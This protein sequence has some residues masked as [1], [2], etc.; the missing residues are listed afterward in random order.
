MSR[1]IGG[2]VMVP[3][4]HLFAA[5]VRQDVPVHPSKP[6]EFDEETET[7][8]CH[9]CNGGKLLRSKGDLMQHLSTDGHQMA[10]M[11]WTKQEEQT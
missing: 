7:G 6:L 10:L 8:I 1:S 11:N 5:S 2:A 3:P 4:Q 9:I